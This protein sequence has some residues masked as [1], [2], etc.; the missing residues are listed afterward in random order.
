M[1]LRISHLVAAL[2]LLSLGNSQVTVK[3]ADCTDDEQATIDESYAS[4]ES[5][6]ATTCGADV[7]STECQD[8]LLNADALPDCTSSDGNNY[9][10]YLVT[11]YACTETTT[12]TS[13]ST[14]DTCSEDVE[15]QTFDMIS[16]YEPDTCEADPCETSCYNLLAELSSSLVSCTTSDGYNYADYYNS[17]IASCSETSSSAGS[18]TTSSTTSASA[19]SATGSSGSTATSATGSKETTSSAESTSSS[20]A[21]DEK[22]TAESS[23]SSASASGSVS[24]SKDNGAASVSGSALTS[25]VIAGTLALLTVQS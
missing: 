18:S 10:E 4:I 22:D 19:S 7:C 11:S 25:L 3:A 13:A 12:S 1:T 5:G 21:T 14:G 9:Y 20:E 8:E 24:A 15:T 23:A 2:L 17:W 16:S 6:V